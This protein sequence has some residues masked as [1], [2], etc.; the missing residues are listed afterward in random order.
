[1]WECPTSQFHQVNVLLCFLI[2]A[3][4]LGKEWHC[5]V[6]LICI[7]L[8]RNEFEHIIICL[9]PKN[10]VLMTDLSFAHFL[11]KFWPFLH[12]SF[13]VYYTLR[14]LSLYLWYML[15]IFPSNF[16]VVFWLLCFCNLKIKKILGERFYLYFLLLQLAFESLL[17][18]LSSSQVIKS[19]CLLLVLV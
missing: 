19:L 12:S 16:E 7:S 13:K 6:L 14:T 2:F 15:Q 10:Y 3:K 11:I 9:G 17:E 8:M 4:Y 5:R 18:S 1:M